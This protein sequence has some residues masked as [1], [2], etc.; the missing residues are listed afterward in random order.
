[1]IDAKRAFA[2]ANVE[3]TA[4]K[5]ILILQPHIL[6]ASTNIGILQFTTRRRVVLATTSVKQRGGRHSL[7]SP[8]PACTLL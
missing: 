5:Y 6:Q 4:S 7:S 1:M 8:R 2:M 3:Q